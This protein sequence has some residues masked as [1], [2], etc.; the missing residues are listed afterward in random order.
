[1]TV[2]TWNEINALQSKFLNDMTP[3]ERATLRVLRG[4][5]VAAARALFDARMQRVQAKLDRDSIRAWM[6]KSLID[7]FISDARYHDACA[8][9]LEAAVRIVR[10]DEPLPCWA[11]EMAT[12]ERPFP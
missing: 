11:R 2:M 4:G 7:Q 6:P 10:G 9:A 3:T 5:T 8:S 1:M 12:G